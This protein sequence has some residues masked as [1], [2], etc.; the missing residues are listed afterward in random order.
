MACTATCIPGHI[1]RPNPNG[2]LKLTSLGSVVFKKRSG[3]NVSGS[4]NI[5]GSEVIALQ[6]FVARCKSA[7]IKRLLYVG[8]YRAALGNE[9]AF[10]RVVL[11]HRMR[12][13]GRRNRP[14]PVGTYK[15]VL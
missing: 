8:V 6:E 7:N 14:P 4:G 12:K 9:H 10:E 2:Y 11:G 15:W 3:L 13:S 5:S 1:L